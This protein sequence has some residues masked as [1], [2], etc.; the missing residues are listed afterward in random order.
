[1]KNNFPEQHIKL[2]FS[3]VLKVK[4]R[5]ISLKKFR[6]SWLVRLYEMNTEA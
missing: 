3:I 2:L 6:V 1:M 5:R 4:A